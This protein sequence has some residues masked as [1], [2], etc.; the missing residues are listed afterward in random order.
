MSIPTLST[1]IYLDCILGTGPYTCSQALPKIQS[2]RLWKGEFLVDSCTSKLASQ[3]HHFSMGYLSCSQNDWWIESW[4][5]QTPIPKFPL[6]S[7]AAWIITRGSWRANRSLIFENLPWCI[8]LIGSLSPGW[9][10][11]NDWEKIGSYLASLN[12]PLLHYMGNS[13]VTWT[14][15]ESTSGSIWLK[16]YIGPFRWSCFQLWYV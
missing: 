7:S 14:S 5:V 13:K 2:Y 8:L 3:I 10:G 16:S 11:A 1:T 12:K 6:S 9:Q 15:E 4:C